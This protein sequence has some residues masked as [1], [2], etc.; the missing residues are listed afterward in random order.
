MSN[1]IYDLLQDDALFIKYLPG[2][3]DTLVVSFSG[4]GL[5]SAS[6]PGIEFVGSSSDNGQNHVLFVSDASRCWLNTPCMAERIIDVIEKTVAEFD[7]KR[8][9]ALGNSMGGSMAL[10]LSRMIHFDAVLA[11]VPQYSVDP[12]VVPNERRWKP[13]RDQIDT[14]RFSKIDSLRPDRTKYFIVHAGRPKELPQV[15]RFQE[16]RGV[17]HYVLPHMSYRLAARL[18]SE[19]TLDPLIRY[20]LAGARGRF[21]KHIF[22][23]GGE[24]RA[25]FVAKLKVKLEAKLGVKADA[26]TPD[27]ACEVLQGM[28]VTAS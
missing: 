3:G 25:N 4:E 28:R 11:I 27:V 10:I 16:Q 7:I 17:G 2:R 23:L 13:F 22:D 12:A 15:L 14:F 8:V 1:Q 19:G 24:F 20:A 21:R 9:V 5:D 6:V 26:W 18:K